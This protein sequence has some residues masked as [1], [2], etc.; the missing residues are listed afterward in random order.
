MALYKYSSFPFLYPLTL[1]PSQKFP[2]PPQV[3]SIERSFLK[4]RLVKSHL[5]SKIVQLFKTNCKVCTVGRVAWN[6]S[7]KNIV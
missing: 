4:L 2:A 7:E 6:R 5:R 1:D 3:V